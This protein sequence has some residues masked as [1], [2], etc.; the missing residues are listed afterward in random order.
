MLDGVPAS[1]NISRS[2]IRPRA[3]LCT[4]PFD[5][6]KLCATRL[7]SLAEGL[8]VDGQLSSLSLLLLHL[9]K[10]DWSGGSPKRDEREPGKDGRGTRLG[11]KAM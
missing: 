3:L 7:M 5:L 9:V 4:L 8:G 2:G 11:S 1:Q 6:S 10:R